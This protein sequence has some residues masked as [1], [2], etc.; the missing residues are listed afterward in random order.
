[1]LDR[2]GLEAIG[3]SEGFVKR[4]GQKGGNQAIGVSRGGRTTKIHAVLDSKGRPLSFTVTGGKVHD[5]QV[6]EE[7]LNTPRSPLAITADKAYDSEKARQQIRDEGA[8]LV[9]PNRSNATRK[10]Y[11]PKRF[12]RRRHKIENFLCRIKDWRRVATRYEWCT[13]A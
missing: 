4:D 3:G 7:I 9:I 11:C 12:Y 2:I 8:L 13:E 10:A 5:S 6:V 1:M